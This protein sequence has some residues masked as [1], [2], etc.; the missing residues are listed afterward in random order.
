MCIFVFVY[1]IFMNIFSGL[2]FESL[3]TSNQDALV[4]CDRLSQI[5]NWIRGVENSKTEYLKRGISRCCLVV[6]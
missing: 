1:F 5:D 2:S 6:C 3:S 4:I